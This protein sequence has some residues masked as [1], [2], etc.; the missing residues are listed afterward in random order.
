MIKLQNI[1]YLMQYLNE[2]NGVETPQRLK[3]LRHIINVASKFLYIDDIN[4]TIKF[5]KNKIKLDNR[6]DL[7]DIYNVT[8]GMTKQQKDSNTYIITI[9]LENL[10]LTTKQSKM[11]FQLLT[12]ILHELQHVSD[13]KRFN[14]SPETS[15]QAF[16]KIA[17]QFNKLWNWY[18]SEN[19]SMNSRLNNPK[20]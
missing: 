16:E 10:K 15:A 18:T 5:N 17:P 3:S 11:D 1:K 12:T 20:C 9:F 2:L 4:V 14:R 8:V 6:I 19:F 7:K 13:Q